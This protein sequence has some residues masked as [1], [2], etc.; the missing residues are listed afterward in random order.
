[1]PKRSRTLRKRP[2]NAKRRRGVAPR[3]MGLRSLTVQRNPIMARSQIVRF[4]YADRV[5]IDPAVDTVASHIFRANSLFAPDATG[6]PTAHQ[7]LGRDEYES[8]YQ[9]YTVIGSK[10]KATYFPTGQTS[11]G[12]VGGILLK[13]NTTVLPGVTHML[14]QGIA[15]PRS[16]KQN[17]RPTSVRLGF[18]PKRFFGVHNITDNKETLGAAFSQNPSQLAFW[19]VYLAPMDS[20]TNLAA[21][22]VLVEIEYTCLLTERKTIGQ[23]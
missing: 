2:R 16:L 20:T 10:I 4:K 21:T 7:P 14:E 19:H 5:L 17:D 12:M 6:S 18:S 23:S 1:M 22:E 15:R 11:A 9:T 3:R 13:N 8:F